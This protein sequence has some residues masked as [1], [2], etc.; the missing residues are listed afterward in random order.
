MGLMSVANWSWLLLAVLLT[1]LVGHLVELLFLPAKGV[2]T[3]GVLGNE[4]HHQTQ[5]QLRRQQR[6]LEK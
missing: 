6:L 4:Q 5:L 3:L 1:V 2:S